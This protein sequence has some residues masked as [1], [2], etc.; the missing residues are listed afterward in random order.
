MHRHTPTTILVLAGMLGTAGLL[1]LAACGGGGGGSATTTGGGQGPVVTLPPPEPFDTVETSWR[2][3]HDGKPAS[4]VAEYLGVHASGGPWQ[5]GPDFTWTH[6]PGLVRFASPPV[7]RLAA[8]ASERER[9]IAAYAVALINRALPYDRHL[10]IGADAPAGVA[11]Q[12]QQRLPNIPDGELFVEFINAPPPG[13]PAWLRGACPSGRA[14]G[15]RHAAEP[16]GEKGPPG[17]VGRDGS[18]FL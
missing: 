15:V 11:G 6:D 14:D 2:R 13:R 10:T 5:A 16:M 18:G 4:R 3:S 7:V 8:G 9:A 17:L 12:W 1:A